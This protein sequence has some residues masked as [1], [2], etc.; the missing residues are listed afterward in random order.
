[1]S[2]VIVKDKLPLFKKNLYFVYNDALREGSRDILVKA[3]ERAPLKKG[4]LRADSNFGQIG[5]LRWRTSF[6]KEYARFQEFGGDGKRKVR[7]YT[8]PG[9]GKAYLKRSGDEIAK[10]LNYTF[11]KHSVRARV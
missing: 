2:R 6:W 8:T 4:H 1:M 7:H 3:K 11:K 10:K 9:T 5:V